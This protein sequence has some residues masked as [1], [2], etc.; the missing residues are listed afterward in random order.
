MFKYPCVWRSNLWILEYLFIKNTYAGVLNHH[1]YTG[2]TV[3]TLYGIW[4]LRRNT[5]P[6]IKISYD[7]IP[8]YT[9]GLLRHTIHCVETRQF[10]KHFCTVKILG[11]DTVHTKPILLY[12]SV[13]KTDGFLR[14]E[15]MLTMRS[16]PPVYYKFRKKIKHK[17]VQLIDIYFEILK[18]KSI[19]KNYTGTISNWKPGERLQAPGNL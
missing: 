7:I 17:K 19:I 11:K 10:C 13:C 9:G 18:K 15:Y 1:L 2:L 5:Q 6:W 8:Y 16:K 12:R 3:C 4:T 14:N